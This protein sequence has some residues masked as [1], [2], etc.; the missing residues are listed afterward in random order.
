[1]SFTL[2][3]L[4]SKKF[5]RTY[6]GYTDNLERRVSEHNS[7]KVVATKSYRPWVILY[8]ENVKSKKDAKN[9]ERY[10]KT[11]AGRRNIKRILDGF[12]PKFK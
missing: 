1:M 12:P 2:Y 10:W 11:G 9:R 5:P 6:V 7:G 3:I 4:C 8:T